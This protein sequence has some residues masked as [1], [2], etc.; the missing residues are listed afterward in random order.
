[1]ALFYGCYRARTSAQWAMLCMVW[2]VAKHMGEA[3]GIDYFAK[4]QIPI[5]PQKLYIL[6]DERAPPPEAALKS[7][8]EAFL[9]DDADLTEINMKNV[10]EAL[11]AKFQCELKEKKLFIKQCVAD[12]N[13]KSE[14]SDSDKPPDKPPAHK[15][16][17]QQKPGSPPPAVHGPLALPSWRKGTGAGTPT[18]PPAQKTPTAPRKRKRDDASS[19]DSSVT[20]SPPA[21]KKLDMRTKCANMWRLM[22]QHAEQAQKHAEQAL[23][24]QKDFESLM[25]VFKREKVEGF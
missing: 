12:W 15:K 17:K 18:A 7:A 1:M 24:Q 25:R 10:R 11:E 13:D 6:I 16:P 9:D 8:V 22:K 3:T 5:N 19:V 2:C 14:E 21:K 20:S 4:L 23:Q